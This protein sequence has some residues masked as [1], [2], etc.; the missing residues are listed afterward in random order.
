[1]IFPNFQ[2]L[3]STK[4]NKSTCFKLNSWAFRAFSNG[5]KRD[6]SVWSQC[7]A[8]EH[9]KVNIPWSKQKVVNKHFP[10]CCTNIWRIITMIA[11]IWCENAFI[12]LS[13]NIICSSSFTLGK[14]VCISEQIMSADKY[15][16]TSSQMEAIVYIKLNIIQNSVGKIH[17][18]TCSDNWWSSLQS[19]LGKKTN[20]KGESCYPAQYNHFTFTCQTC[21]HNGI[22]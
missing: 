20:R 14:D 18:H 12:Y 13:L 6:I 9:W 1:M 11:S 3:A 10:A 17:L 5:Y 21:T 8:R 16:N 22:L 7:H 2:T 19:D 15:T 4:Y